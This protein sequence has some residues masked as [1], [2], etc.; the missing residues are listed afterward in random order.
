MNVILASTSPY[1]R[2]I[3]DNLHLH[4]TSARPDIDESPRAEESPAALVERL[5]REKA[6]AVDAPPDAFVIGSDQVAELD[7]QIL[8]KPLTEERAFA[9]LKACSGREV[10][11]HTGLCLRRGATH[12]SVVEPFRVRFRDLQD[13]DIRHYL[14]E[15]RP[16][17]CAGSFKSEGLGILLFTALDGRDPN[18]LIGLPVIALAELFREYGVNLL[19]HTQKL[20]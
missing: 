20:A 8:G 3:L 6:F 11:F 4:F 5:A 7:G 12:Q 9:Q 14:A 18:A 17:D 13:A 19:M 10:V 1:R 15:E 2:A 16:L